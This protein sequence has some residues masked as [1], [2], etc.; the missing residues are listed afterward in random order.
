M[1]KKKSIDPHAEREARK[2]AQPIAS[3]ELI[4]EYLES[5]GAPLNRDQIAAHFGLVDDD[6]YF[7]L[8][9]RLRAMERDG[10]II[11]TRKGGYGLAHKMDLVCGRV[12]GH[13]DG[14]GFLIPDD[15]SDDLF[16]APRD[17]R[18]VFHGDRVMARVAGEDRRG[19]RMGRIVEVL[20][21]AHELMVGRFFV[22]HGVAFVVADNK[23]ITQDIMVAAE[24]FNGATHGQ[25]VSLEIIQQPTKRHQALGRVK[26]VMGE[27]MAPGLEIDIAIRSHDL[28][29][30]W[31]KKVIAET[32]NLPVEVFPTEIEGRIDIRDLPLVTI[33]GEDARDFDDAVYCEPNANGWRLIV[34]I[35]D[36]SNYVKPD[37]PLDLEAQ[38]RAT[39]VYFPERVIP[40]LPEALSNG[41]CSLNPQ[42]NRLCMVCDMQIS[43]QGT[44]KDY[45]FYQAVMYSHARLTY[46]QVG[47]M[48]EQQDKTLRAEYKAVLPHLENLYGMY[49]AMR[50]QR[51]KRGAIDFETTEVRIVFGSE[52]KIDKIIP[53]YRND[54]HKIIE[55]CMITANVATARFLLKN[56][57][58]A[59]Y[60][61]HEG[62]TIEKLEDLRKFLSEFGLQVPGGEKPTAKDY[63][64]LVN[65][66]KERPDFN[67]IQTVLLRSLRQAVYSPDNIGHFGLAYDAYA[68]FTSPIRRY[69]DLLV[70]RAIKHVLSKQ[71]VANYKY[72]HKDMVHFGDI[73]SQNERRAD[74]ATRDVNDWLKCEFMLDKVGN[75]Y[76]G[77]ITTVTGFGLFVELND[78]FVE[79]LVHV[80]SLD[81]DYYHFD[82]VK[83]RLIGENS[84]KIY[85]LGNDITIRVAR[86]D[87]DERKIDFDLVLSDA[88]RK[89]AGKPK[90][91]SNR[92]KDK[93]SGRKKP[94]RV[95]GAKRF[96]DKKEID[97]ASTELDNKLTHNRKTSK[98][99]TAQKKSAA[100]VNKKKI[101]KKKVSKKKNSKKKVT[102]KKT[103]KKKITK[104]KTSKKKVANKKTVSKKK[105]RK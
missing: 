12:Q 22:E 13:P 95:S 20:E 53:V 72:D 10:Q 56:N 46:T 58:P 6:N 2:Y 104:K 77:K 82:P 39:S 98:K 34:A 67:L 86:V 60:R 75:E 78:I 45:K 44:L 55:E 105:A 90:S 97:I 50:A 1:S 74:E 71:S 69:P 48:L 5:M 100:K 26:E 84:N 18:E 33:D 42:V 103:A 101:I 21:R 19:R 73:C 54:A 9:K 47:A 99:K 25:I 11:Y 4:M 59:L 38:N 61:I 49:K 92:R 94:H 81:N 70:H 52:R 15:N 88:D 37:A 35:A 91:K 27:H 102:K 36:V 3:R 96:A 8:K 31:N 62:P 43:K 51:S 30:H 85:G 16:L 79:G 14:F 23:R 68:H 63:A 7:A 29:N 17:M 80:T 87:L 64:H 40:M 89:G 93:N 76:P 57:M 65:Q 28:P 83:H 41:L 66:I 24:D 32:D